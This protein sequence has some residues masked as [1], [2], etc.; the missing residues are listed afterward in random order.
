MDIFLA[1]FKEAFSNYYFSIFIHI[2]IF[3]YVV[4][5]V[6]KVIFDNKTTEDNK[7]KVNLE[8]T[9]EDK[10]NVFKESFLKKA[11]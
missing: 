11:N 9:K 7:E 1:M 6:S 5:I 4:L 8:K 10:L 2:L 3:I